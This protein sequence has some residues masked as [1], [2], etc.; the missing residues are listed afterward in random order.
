MAKK[1]HLFYI[2]IILILCSIIGTR[3]YFDGKSISRN[4]DVIRQSREN[5]DKLAITNKELTTRNSELEKHTIELRTNNQKLRDEN[6][7]LRII[8]ERIQEYSDGTNS[9]IE[10]AVLINRRI[11]SI[12][13]EIGD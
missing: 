11:Q 13:K 6:N 5:I 2:S 4:L 1:I 12:L 7:K 10:N 3:L 8:S 9:G